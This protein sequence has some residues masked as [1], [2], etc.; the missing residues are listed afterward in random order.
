M[1]AG[2]GSAAP[3]TW[4][5]DVGETSMFSKGNVISVVLTDDFVLAG[6]A[7]ETNI[8][9]EELDFHFGF[10]DDSHK[11]RLLEEVIGI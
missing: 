3:W 7:D 4:V 6:P 10:S 9:F 8:A 11:N 5:R 1:T 2:P